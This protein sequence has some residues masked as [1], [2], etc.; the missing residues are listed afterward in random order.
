MKIIRTKVMPIR[1]DKGGPVRIKATCETSRESWT[2]EF[3]VVGIKESHHIEAAKILCHKNGWFGL[4]FTTQWI[5]GNR[6]MKH[7]EQVNTWVS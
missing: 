4:S 7:I 6:E 2:Q 1:T 3:N 5:T